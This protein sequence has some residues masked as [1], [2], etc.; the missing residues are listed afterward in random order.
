MRDRLNTV[1]STPAAGTADGEDP[2]AVRPAFHDAR[3][4]A[5]APGQSVL[6]GA[7]F[8]RR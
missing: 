8:T 7:A 5:V 1:P 4:P 6:D 2:S 3:T